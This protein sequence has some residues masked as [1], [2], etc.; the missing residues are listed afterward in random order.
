MPDSNNLPATTADAPDSTNLPAK[1]PQWGQVPGMGP[2]LSSF[3]VSTPEGKIGLFNAIQ[4]ESQKAEKWINTEL[5]VVHVV[6]HG[7]EF[8]GEDGEL[9]NQTRTVLVLK[10]GEQIG[11]VSQGIVKA[12]HMIAF[13]F[14]PPPWPQGLKCRL[15]QEDLGNGRRWFK[16]T[17]ILT[18]KAKK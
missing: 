18:A 13:A 17:P 14:G 1:H 5:E 9:V 10:G 7:A 16:L 11:F 6:C 4:G 2:I 3:D 15:S 8:E 12:I